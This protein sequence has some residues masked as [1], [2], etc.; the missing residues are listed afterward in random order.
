MKRREFITL[1][2]GAAAAWPLAARAQQPKMPI[3]G[4]LTGGPPDPSFYTVVAFRRGL[5][6]SGYF[7]GQNVTIEYRG[8]ENQYD[9]LPA[10]AADL[11]SR[12][13][14]VIFATG[15]PASP[16][17]AK[18]ATASIPIVFVTG[19]DPV[20]LGLVASLSRPAGNITGVVFLTNSLA[21]KRMGLLRDLLPKVGAVGFIVNPYSLNAESETKDA[22]AAAA[23]LGV[24]LIVVKAGTES[25]FDPVFTALVQQHADA[26][27]VTGDAFLGRNIGSIV[28]L[29]QRHKL[30]A[31]YDRREYADAG[32]LMTYGTS[33]TEANRQGALYTGRILKGASPAELPVLQPTKFE[34]VINLKTARALGL[35]IPPGVLAIADE[36]IE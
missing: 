24:R 13:A 14:N 10:L 19:G 29:A 36:V 2:G 35:S 16:L 31:I 12:R 25:D 17:A 33:L 1:L 26:F 30:P 27:L 21:A 28:T 15:G 20:R 6:E 23:A 18:A 4:Y 9:Q 32:G 5:K 7:D 3:I 8:A 34:F 22:Q 11:V